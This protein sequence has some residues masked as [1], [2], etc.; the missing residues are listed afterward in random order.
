M[1]DGREAWIAELPGE[2]RGVVARG[3]RH[4]QL[5]IQREDDPPQHRLGA[6]LVGRVAAVEAALAGAFVDLGGPLPGFLP[7]RKGAR[8]AEG[9]RLEL[10]VA[11]EPRDGKGPQLRLVGPG[12]G[13]PRLLQPGPD[14]AARLAE[15]APG[16]RPEGGLAALRAAEA[17]EAEALARVA[18]FPEAGVDLSVER[19]RALVAIDVDFTGAAGRD[20]RRARARANA[21]ALGQAARLIG[22]KGWGGLVCVDLAGAGH[23]GAAMAQA[24]RRAFGEAAVLGPLSRFGLLQ[25]AMPW[26]VRPAEQLLLDGAGR[27]SLRT[28][29]Q[30]LVRAA[31]MAELADTATPR[32]T[33]VCNPEEAAAVGPLLARLGPR[34]AVRSDPAAA[35]GAGRMEEG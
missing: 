9:D 21:F 16:V 15:L 13:P 10:E 27:P 5:I 30:A 20:P 35:P 24:A 3:D 32:W 11:A 29:V 12:D 1:S 7:L 23:D 34:F 28:R 2:T 6:R 19:T 17:A 18:L 8:P 33:C 26:R 4:E 22:L 25:L 14:V 31:R